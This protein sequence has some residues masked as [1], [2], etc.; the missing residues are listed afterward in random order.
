LKSI[1][2]S[3]IFLTFADII[4]V[5]CIVS[6]DT[7]GLVSFFSWSNVPHFCLFACVRRC[8]LVYCLQWAYTVYDSR[9]ESKVEQVC[10]W[11]RSARRE[12]NINFNFNFTVDI[13]LFYSS[14]SQLLV[15]WAE[16]RLSPQ[17]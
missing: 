10:G 9:V 6:L 15:C 4:R 5:Y 14:C 12:S 3:I 17:M 16:S 8:I 2:S 1:L 7:F 11:G 13:Y